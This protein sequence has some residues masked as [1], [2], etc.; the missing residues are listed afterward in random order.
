MGPGMGTHFQPGY[1]PSFTVGSLGDRLENHIGIA[2]PL[3]CERAYGNGNIVDLRFDPSS[4]HYEG[5]VGSGGTIARF[6]N[7]GPTPLTGASRPSIPKS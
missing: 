4:L 1:V 5:V 6:A 2:R 7:T 3:R